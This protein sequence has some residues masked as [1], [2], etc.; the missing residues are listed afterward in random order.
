MK[1]QYRPYQIVCYDKDNYIID[2]EYYFEAP[3]N[4]DVEFMI[5]ALDATWAQCYY[6]YGDGGYD[7][8]LFNFIP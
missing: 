4:D 5:N 3:S 8:H 1:E 7:K 6:D 2:C